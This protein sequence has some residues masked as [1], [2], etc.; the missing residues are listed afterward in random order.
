MTLDQFNAAR[1][2]AGML[3]LYHGDNTA[4]PVLGVDFAEQ[5]VGL[6]GAQRDCGE[7]F[8]ARCENVTVLPI[9]TIAEPEAQP[10]KRG[11]QF[12]CR[13]DE[14]LSFHKDGKF[15]LTLYAPSPPSAA[16]LEEWLR[17]LQQTETMEP[18]S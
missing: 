10:A 7:I 4:Y 18:R 14:M 16:Q 2:T 9:N 11:I 17:S 15:W 1:W 13:E 6:K 5:L 12:H 8:W 3:A